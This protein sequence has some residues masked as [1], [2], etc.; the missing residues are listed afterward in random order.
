ML[1]KF[2]GNDTLKAFGISEGYTG[3]YNDILHTYLKERYS[4]SSG[5]KTLTDL[6]NL[7][8]GQLISLSNPTALSGCVLWL[9]AS[10][11]STITLSGSDV[12][13]W[14]DKSGQGN[15]AAQDGAAA[16]PS[17]GINTINSLNV[18]DFTSASN[19]RLSIGQPASLDFLPMTDSFTIIIVAKYGNTATEVIFGKAGLTSTLRQ[20]MV[21]E[22]NTGMYRSVIGG[23]FNSA[24]SDYSGAAHVFVTA[25]STVNNETS[26]D[27]TFLV[28]N[29]ILS[30]ASNANDVLIGGR[31]S[32]DANGGL[33]LP[34]NGDIAEIIVYNEFKDNGGLAI[35]T[36][37]LKTKWGIT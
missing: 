23:A 7:W 13:L 22:A 25:V 3:S 17:S 16:M 28:S 32:D 26:I 1:N 11:T 35:L 4:S 19:E 30:T 9:D 37:R 18:I 21:Y 36:S 20:Y 12:T 27:G 8:D 10:D 5:G 24:N 15:D 33:A 29:S 14:E 2:P 34:Y 31:R 6:M